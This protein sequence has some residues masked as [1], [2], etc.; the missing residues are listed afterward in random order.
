MA[1]VSGSACALAQVNGVA[2]Y[3]TYLTDDVIHTCTF[4]EFLRIQWADIMGGF[5]RK[6]ALKRHFVRP[7]ITGLIGDD[8]VGVW[9]YRI[10]R[11]LRVGR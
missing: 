3:S 2:I 7:I 11:C 10:P 6:C 8:D 1:R 5:G 9:G 4:Y